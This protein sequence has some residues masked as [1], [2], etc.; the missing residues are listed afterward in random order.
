MSSKENYLPPHMR[1]QDT[2]NDLIYTDHSYE[3][4]ECAEDIY[5]TLS[6]VTMEIIEIER[7][8]IDKDGILN[9]PF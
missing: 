8:Y 9:P 7:T 1:G 3:A 4:I 5:S 2:I 6:V